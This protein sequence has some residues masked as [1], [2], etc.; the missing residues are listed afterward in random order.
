MAGFATS[1]AADAQRRLARRSPAWFALF[2]AIFTRALQRDFHAVR[3]AK[4]GPPPDPQTPRLLVYMNHPSWWDA[5]II[6]VLIARLFPGRA[7]FAPIDDAMTR[8]Y[9][10]MPRIGAFGVAQDSLRGAAVFLETAAQIL[11]RPDGLLF[12][13]AQGRFADVRERPIRLAPGLAHL[14]DRVPD[15]T[16]VPMAVDYPFWDERKPELLVRFGD[17]IAARTL[18]PLDKRG[19]HEALAGPLEAGMEALTLDALARDATRFTT[20]LDGG[21]GVGGLYDAWRRTRAALRG[22]RFTAAHGGQP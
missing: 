17:P 6:T 10:F 2:A 13:T 15:A 4:A 11:G 1:L 20:L 9:G 12:V 5:A 22:E 3:I 19:R 16:L 8:R 18:L 21:A 7:G 14:I